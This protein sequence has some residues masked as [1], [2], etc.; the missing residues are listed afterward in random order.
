MASR[1]HSPPDSRVP[2][3]DNIRSVVIVFVVLFHAILPYSQACPWWYVVDSQSIPLAILLIILLEPI[4]MPALFFISGLLA[5]P[6]W[7]R[8]GPSRF[9]VDKVKRL[10]VPFLLCTFLF[11]P[12]MPFIRQWVRAADGGVH[13]LGFWAFWLTFVQSGSEIHSGPVILN[14]DLVV[15]QYWFLMLLFVFFCGFCLYN[16]LRGGA[17]GRQSSSLRAQR[18]NPTGG[19]TTT[20]EIASSPASRTPRND[21][22]GR[23]ASPSRT[24]LLVGFAAF[25]LVIG[26]VYAL[27]CR[28]IDGTVWVTVGS[29]LQVQPAKVPIYLAFFLA[30]I[31]VERRD[32]LPR[33]L[34]TGRP[35]IWFGVSFMAFAAY[36][37]A[38]M[39]T[40]PVEDPS[41]V[42]QFAG[43]TLRLFY[44]VAV[45]LW[46]LSFFNRH[47]NRSTSTWEEL[48]SNSY[49]I[50]LIHMVPQVVVQ[51][52]VLSLPIPAVLKF[53]IAFLVTLLI[54]YLVSRFLVRKSAT[55]TILGMVLLFIVLSLWFR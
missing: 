52:I 49:N 34:D 7:E 55:A 22:Q 43:R 18:S 15:S 8:K 19:G 28:H 13:P 4:L 31:Y 5:W 2:Y 37:A 23:E 46:S 11:S 27:V 44:V 54:S 17:G 12:I 48:S 47:L 38:V 14:P 39:V 3:L 26:L 36:F 53:A 45:S 10:M 51:L 24:G 20:R 42:L 35:A 6:S 29:L 9:M 40:F 1:A 32:L 16:L 41:P 21:S 30:G 50:Y 33:I 25:A